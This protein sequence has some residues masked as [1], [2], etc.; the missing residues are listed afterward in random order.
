MGSIFGG[1]R[2]DFKAA[3]QRQQELI[4]MYRQGKRQNEDDLGWGWDLVAMIEEIEL[5]IEEAHKSRKT[6]G[7]GSQSL[8]NTNIVAPM[9][10]HWVLG[11][12][13]I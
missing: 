3:R 8:K 2:Y 12:K 1:V 9:I 7:Q 13:A 11:G 10:P 4:M 5:E 6:A